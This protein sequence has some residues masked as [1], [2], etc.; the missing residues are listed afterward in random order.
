MINHFIFQLNYLYTNFIVNYFKFN[1]TVELNNMGRYNIEAVV[2]ESKAHRA[3][4]NASNQLI[5][6]FLFPQISFLDPAQ[7]ALNYRH[8]AK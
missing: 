6:D 8:F 1:L 2:D 3:Y 7:F 4:Y 5:A